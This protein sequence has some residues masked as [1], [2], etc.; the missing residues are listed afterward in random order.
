MR[1]GVATTILTGASLILSGQIDFMLL[2]LF[3][4]VITRVYAPFDQSLAIIAEMFISQVSADRINEIYETPI[5]TGR[6]S[7]SPKATTS[8]LTMCAFPMARRKCCTM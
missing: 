5:A 7:F 8:C 2:F 3:L 4:L 1:L 6:M